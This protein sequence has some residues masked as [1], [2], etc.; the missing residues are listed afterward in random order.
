MIKYYLK[1]YFIQIVL[2]IT[3]VTSLVLG[4]L[5]SPYIFA[6]MFLNVGYTVLNI[7]TLRKLNAII[8]NLRSACG[9]KCN[10]YNEYDRL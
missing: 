4:F 2:T 10:H 7:R 3:G 6:L 5:V 9:V 1:N 8:N